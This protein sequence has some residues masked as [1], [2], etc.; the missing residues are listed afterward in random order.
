MMVENISYGRSSE[1]W[2]GHLDMLKLLITK[3]SLIRICE[4]GGGANPAI[5][6]EYISEKNLDY[7]VLDISKDELEKAPAG[8][9]K[10][11]ADICAM[12]FDIPAEYDLVFT[13][14]LAEH[15]KNGEL[16]HKN[17]FK[18][19]SKG[20]IAFHFF[21]TLYTLPFLINRLAP[22]RLSAYLLDLFAP[23]D[24]LRHK[25]F[26]AYYNWC[27]GPTRKQIEKFSNL[28]YE[29]VEYKGFFGHEEYYKKLLWVMNLSALI[30]DYLVQYPVPQ[31]TSYAYVILRKK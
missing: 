14:M 28:G 6:I 30:S 22:E 17:I 25:K 20:G 31:L 13:K 24:Q 8:Y 12:N 9:H 10:V 27:R 7:T 15:V 21:P 2:Q 4:V 11:N 18:I 29:L 3:Y 1:A 23:R 26:P 5:P 19:L 16:M